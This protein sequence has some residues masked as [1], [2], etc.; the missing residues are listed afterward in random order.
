M[1]RGEAIMPEPPAEATVEDAGVTEVLV[2]VATKEAAAQTGAAA[3][4]TVEELEE[5]RVFDP[6]SYL[7]FRV[8]IYRF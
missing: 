7:F 4:V 1:S 5:V 3:V 2:P 8:A 6:S